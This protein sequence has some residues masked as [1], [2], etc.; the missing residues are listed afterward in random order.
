MVMC[1]GRR[2]PAGGP[3]PIAFARDF[4]ARAYADVGELVADRASRWVI[5]P[6]RTSSTRYTRSPR[7]H[8][9][10]VILENRWRAP[11]DRLRRHHCVGQRNKVQL[12]IF[13][14][15]PCLGPGDPC[16]ASAHSSGRA[17]QA[18]H[19]QLL[20]L[21]NFLYRP[22][23]PEELDTTLGGGIMFNQVPHQSR[24]CAASGGG[25]VKSV[26]RAGR[27][28]RIPRARPKEAASHSCSSRMAPPRAGLQWLRLF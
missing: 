9:K 13:G 3:A 15:H 14:P 27:R 17:W 11:T 18:R 8:G 22:R 12:V 23:R 7:D 16:D 20:Q 26:T 2:R 6:P 25:L 21:H 5:S 1:C 28:A 19:D 10:H 24:H 4:N